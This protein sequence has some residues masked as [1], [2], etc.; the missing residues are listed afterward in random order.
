MRYSFLLPDASIKT[1]IEPLVFLKRLAKLAQ[2]SP[3]YSCELE[4]SALLPEVTFLYLYPVVTAPHTGLRGEISWRHDGP[5][6]RVAVE[7]RADHWDTPSGD[8][9]Y[10]TYVASLHQLTASLLELYNAQYKSRRC[11]WIEKEAA[12]IPH[13][14]PR[15]QPYFKSFVATLNR[16]CPHPNDM[17]RWYA[18]IRLAYSLRCSLDETELQFLLEQEGFSS[19]EASHF[20]S[21]YTMGHELLETPCPPLSAKLEVISQRP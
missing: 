16:Q 2:V 4:N 1:D 11:L 6:M 9:D 19:K 20:V 8:A 14:S 18:F 3:D 21:I 5:K 10:A 17:Q 15:L 12:C 7:V 13:L